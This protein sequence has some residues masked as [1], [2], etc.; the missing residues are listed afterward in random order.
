VAKRRIEDQKEQV[1]ALRHSAPDTALAA[2]RQFLENRTNLVVA[3]AASISA[4]LKLTQVIPDLLRTFDRYFTNPVATDPQCWGKNAIIQALKDLGYDRCAP[5]VRGLTHIQMEPV[6]GTTADTAV[7]L[8]SSC[9]LSLVQCVDIT[10]RDALQ[11]IVDALTDKEHPVRT[12][13]ARALAQMGGDECALLL[14][15]KARSGD[16]EPSISGQI[17]ESLLSLEG[18]RS[19]SFIEQFLRSAKFEIR[20]EAALALGASRL[21][22]A[23]V[24]LKRAWEGELNVDVR[25]SCLRAISVSRNSEALDFLISLVRDGREAECEDALHAMAIHESTSEIYRRV[26]QAVASRNHDRA[27]SLFLRLFQKR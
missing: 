10:R 23:I 16:S 3:K 24:L 6:W 1:S 7:V 11:Y 22:E 4:E 5:F 14:R 21:P 27:Q 13:A 2:L 12:E 26:E 20:E 9:V 15:L 8:R 17:L 25:R 18:E 19:L